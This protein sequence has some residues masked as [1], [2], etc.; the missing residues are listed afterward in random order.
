MSTHDT[1][2]DARTVALRIGVGLSTL[3]MWLSA[4]EERPL[5]ERRFQFHD[6]HGRKRLWSEAGFQAL[7]SAIETESQPG[8]CLGGWRDGSGRC[9]ASGGAKND[10]AAAVAMRKVLAFRHSG[11]TSHGPDT[12]NRVDDNDDARLPALEVKPCPRR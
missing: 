6:Y 1:P 5:A 9:E 4:D 11:V 10:S 3:N 12:Q 2:L 8:G 7:K